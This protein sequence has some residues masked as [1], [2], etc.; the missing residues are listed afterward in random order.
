MNLE[1][2]SA[3]ADAFLDL[4]EAFGVSIQ[5]EDAEILAVVNTVD[6]DRAL[7]EG[8][9]AEDGEVTATILRD[10]LP[11]AAANGKPATYQDRKYHI[12]SITPEANRPTVRIVLR[13]LRGR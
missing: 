13:P 6:V 11:V 5:I 12:R 10:D 4:R 7:V 8:G 1:T 9:F 2:S 3:I